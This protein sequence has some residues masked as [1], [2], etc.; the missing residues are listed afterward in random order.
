MQDGIRRA[1][2]EDQ[3]AITR[4][5]HE[6]RLNPRGLRWQRFVVID[7]G[8]QL[9]GAAQLRQHQ[10]GSRE[11]ASLVVRTHYRGQGLAGAM[12]DSLLA[13]EAGPV[14]TLVDRRYAEH[15]RSW[16]FHRVDPA[17]LPPTMRAQLR[18]GRLATAVGSLLTRRRIVLQP[19]LRPPVD[20]HG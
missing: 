9:V 10:D 14:Y 1:K 5:V 17:S 11:L 4:L 8:G 13:D 6:A 20:Q 3:T 15:F 12:I 16:N 7:R 2:A 19:L 18:I